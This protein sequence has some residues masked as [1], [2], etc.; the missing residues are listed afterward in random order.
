[1]NR[2]VSPEVKE[3]AR[4]N[5]AD[6]VG[7]VRVADLPKHREEMDGQTFMTGTTITVSPVRPN[8]RPRNC[9]D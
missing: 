6:L 5:G 1:M 3:A 2:E 7:I 4:S 8:A 9:P